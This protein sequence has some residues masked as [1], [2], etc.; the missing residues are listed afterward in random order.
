MS[1]KSYVAIALLTCI[2][3]TLLL[4]NFDNHKDLSPVRTVIGLMICSMGFIIGIRATA[5][6]FAKI[7]GINPFKNIK[8]EDDD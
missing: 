5:N 8:F 3:G 7:I 2:I 4:L 1:D 6:M